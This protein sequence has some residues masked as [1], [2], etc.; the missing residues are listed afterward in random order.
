MEK[1]GESY[2]AAR[3]VL[4]AADVPA[5]PS[6]AAETPVLATSEAEIRRRTG[7]GWEQW[8]DLLDEWGAD[9]LTH[10][11]VAR[12]VAGLLGI[13][14]LAWD[15][16]AITYSYER[17]RGLRVVGQRGDGFA[18]TASKTMAVPAAAV[19]DAFV[20][21]ARRTAWLPDGRLTER[22]V[23]RPTSARFDWED[24]P[25]RVNVFV[26]RKGPAKTTVTLEHR[27][28]ADAAEAD[29]MKAFWRERLTSLKRRLEGE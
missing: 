15:A 23:T 4:L 12:R 16:Q 19:F 2:T 26:E 17:A 10:T 14:P 27:R 25:T 28:L 9:T 18:I 5:G 22:T 11:E 24:G 20:D 6:P 29:T 13:E 7:R 8:F 3:A 1:T 21:P